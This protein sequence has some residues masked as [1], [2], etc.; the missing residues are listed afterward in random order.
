[1][2]I[3]KAPTGSLLTFSSLL[4]S[5]ALAACDNLLLDPTASAGAGGKPWKSI[6]WA[7]SGTAPLDGMENIQNYLNTNIFD[8]SSV[9]VIDNSLLVAGATYT[10]SMVVTNYRNFSS[11]ARTTTYIET[12]KE[13]T[14]MAS[15]TPQ[16]TVYGS[17]S[18]LFY[19]S[20]ALSLYASVSIPSCAQG[21]DSF[22]TAPLFYTWRVFKDGSTYDG[23]L[24]SSSVDPRYFKLNPYTLKSASVYTVALQVSDVSPDEFISANFT[25]SY[26]FTVTTA[27]E[28]GVRAIVLGGSAFTVDSRKVLRLDASL[29]YDLDDPG[30]G[31]NN[32]IFK[33]SCIQVSPNF[34]VELSMANVSYESG[35]SIIVFASSQFTGTLYKVLLTVSNV[36]ALSGLHQ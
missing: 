13:Q 18:L 22:L 2:V 6:L 26:F 24:I 4:S 14:G 28:Q 35:G 19:R 20:S 16:V 11:I 36:G 9:I 12:Y 5:L 33:W 32:L 30:N 25:S 27:P 10:F 17:S 15:V 23:S 8:T 3:V 1:M 31:I 29:S 34:G 7:V 21:Y